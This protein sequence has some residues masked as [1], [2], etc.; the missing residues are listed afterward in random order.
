MKKKIDILSFKK[1]Q[2]F[3]NT[4]KKYLN[5]LS[6]NP[7]SKYQKNLSFPKYQAFSR[8]ELINIYDTC[9]NLFNIIIVD[10]SQKLN[11]FHKV[12][13]SYRAWNIIIGTWLFDYIHASYKNYLE[14]KY[15]K[16]NYR[17]KQ[18]EIENYEKY[19]FTTNNSEEFQKI[20]ATTE[21]YLNFNSLL[22]EYFN[23][24]N[25]KIKKNNNLRIKKF[26]YTPKIRK[27]KNFFLDIVYKFYNFFLMP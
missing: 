27:K 20:L 2:I 22:H 7:T 3:L 9:E 24:K 6:K 5:I 19:N 4:K 21:W 11:S 15:I 26:N 10:L 17:M 8:K 16:K 12:N 18:I 25:I 14:L 23:S 1:N 13:Y